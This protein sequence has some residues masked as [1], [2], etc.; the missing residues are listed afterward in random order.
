MGVS[1][2]W[3]SSVQ[4]AVYLY[5]VCLYEMKKCNYLMVKGTLTHVTVPCPQHS[6]VSC[7]AQGGATIGCSLSHDCHMME[8]E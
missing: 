5:P 6:S 1:D 7:D 3:L 8:Q 4:D 2:I